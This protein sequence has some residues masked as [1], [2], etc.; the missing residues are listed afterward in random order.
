MG[1]RFFRRDLS[2]SAAFRDSDRPAP[3]PAQLVSVQIFEPEG[4][5]RAVLLVVQVDY[6]T[7]Q[8]LDDEGWFGF[9]LATLAPEVTSYE[10][11][12]HAPV[13]VE[14]GLEETQRR[15][16][17]AVTDGEA[18]L[19]FLVG[20]LG[21]EGAP[22]LDAAA[23][24]WLGVFQEQAAGATTFRRGFRSVFAKTFRRR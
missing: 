1:G 20:A 17:D 2:E 6:E 24:R 15:E 4:G 3:L 5:P 12:G 9:G 18:V 14:L 16:Y 19:D 11:Y 8:R 10:L 22:L 7:W 21:C 13:E 23:W